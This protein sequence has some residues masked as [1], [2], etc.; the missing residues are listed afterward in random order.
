MAVWVDDGD[1]RLGEGEIRTLGDLGIKSISVVAFISEGAYGYDALVSGATN[2]DG[3][4][5]YAED[6]WFLNQETPSQFD[7]N[8]SKF[9]RPF[10]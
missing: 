5:M 6:V 7:K 9:I 3:R 10:S 2:V 4:G 8:L 1:A